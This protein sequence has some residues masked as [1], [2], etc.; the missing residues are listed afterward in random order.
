M[1]HADRFIHLDVYHVLFLMHFHHQF[2]L[3]LSAGA[4]PPV[5]GAHELLHSISSRFPAA[6][7]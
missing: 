1:L 6:V 5:N 4:F 7:T 3:L 2:A